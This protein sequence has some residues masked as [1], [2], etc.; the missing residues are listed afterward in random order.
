MS[1][2]LESAARVALMKHV[3]PLLKQPTLSQADVE[4]V[5][6]KIQVRFGGEIAPIPPAD[7]YSDGQPFWFGRTISTWYCL[8]VL[9]PSRT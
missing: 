3:W 6:A 4:E 7:G 2:M 1:E 5:E 8:D 9:C